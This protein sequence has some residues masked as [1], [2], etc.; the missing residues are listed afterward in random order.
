MA[1]KK[2]IEDILI[3]GNYKKIEP[4]KKN[5]LIVFLIVLLI[6]LLLGGAG[7]YGWNYY[8]SLQDT[9]KDYFGKYFFNNN[10]IT[11]NKISINIFS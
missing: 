11:I 9:S 6:V 1:D 10:F 2:T 3:D 5:P 4:K 8:M 7:V